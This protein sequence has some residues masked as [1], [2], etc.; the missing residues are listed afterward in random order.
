MIEDW[1]KWPTRSTDPSA[2]A[3]IAVLLAVVIIIALVVGAT[4]LIPVAI[5]FGIAKGV[6]WYLNRPIP[7]DQ[8][9]AKT[10][11][12]V[13]SA[14]FPD[15]DKFMEA[16]LDRFLDAIRDDLPAYGIF[17]TMANIT[18]TIYKK[19]NLNNPL[20]PLATPN[21]IEE[22]RYR[23]QLIAQQRKSVDAPRTLEVFNATLSKCYLDFVAGLPPIA[24]TTPQEF[25]KCEAIE[26]FA[27]FPLIDVLPD[28]GKS[29]WS[30]IRP[31]FAEEVQQIGLFEG[32]RKQ[33]DRN[34][35]ETSAAESSSRN[36]RLI[37]PDKYKGT[38]R[39]IVSAYLS[40][41]PFEALFYAPVP[42]AFTDQQRI[43]HAH[44]VGGSG[45]GKTQLLQRL[46]VDDLSRDT[47]PALI[48][49]DSQGEMLRKIQ[50]LDLFAPGK[51]LADRIVIIDPEDVEYPPA[52]NMFDLKPARLGTYSQTIKEQVEASTIEIFN[53]VFGSLA[54]ELTSRQNTTFAFVTRLMLSVPGATIHTLRELFED[55]AT[56][57][58]KSPFA[59][60]IRKLDPTSQAYF[61]NQ[62]FTK[63]YSQ[64]KQ[65]IARR[66]YTVLQVPA[67]DRMFAAKMNKLDMFEAMQ[68]GSV[69][70]INT[71]K[72]LLKTDASALFGRY[73]I[74]R[75]IAAAF[76]R[77]AVP[78]QDR[79]PAFL[80]VDEAAEYVDDNL[81]ALLSQARKFSLG[82]LFAHQNLDQLTADLRASVAANT[83]IKI[84]GG[85]SD[86]D[87]RSLASDMRTTADF[88][89]GMT[90]RSRSTEFACYVRN[91]TTNAV[92]LEIPFGR[93]EAA[94]KMP[95]GVEAQ[96][97]TRNRARYAVGGN[98]LR[99][100]ATGPG[101]P[102]PGAA[103][104][105]E[106]LVNLHHPDLPWRLEK[107]GDP[108]EP[109]KS[110]R[111]PAGEGDP[112]DEPK[113]GGD[114]K[115]K[116]KWPI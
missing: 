43:E 11:Q 97:I 6:H 51:P 105:Q 102:D 30:L 23:D 33:L 72:A 29:V 24:K 34:S 48:I 38:P 88:I 41:T 58:D 42:F 37:T 57:I 87:A 14:N 53:Y 81:E 98:I 2:N 52:L 50:K 21:D 66:L 63:T 70:L 19:E 84:A 115:G 106:P 78:P 80:I 56:S 92:R 54:A 20:P 110:G 93:L 104:P 64:T 16:H 91:Y 39:E 77:I 12:R 100:D 13:I 28:T 83:S 31:F 17:I 7:T 108:K 112:T 86:K 75:V 89:T 116:K 59:D 44:V 47:P 18:E 27:T 5:V 62:F 68:N 113:P 111:R 32:L 10:E 73:M 22:G 74:A 36:P 76:E 114:D 96:L 99:P 26:S 85:V 71:S 55:G 3:A 35:Q 79:K 103:S 61:Q 82:V 15:A 69:V 101:T 1:F 94:R 109:E 25:S 95:P 46:I 40:N 49:V 90:K 4:I 8:L 60:H 65:Q 107:D 9:Y 45:H 67:F